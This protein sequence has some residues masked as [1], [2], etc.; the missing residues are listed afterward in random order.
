MQW[1]LPSWN[2]DFR[3]VPSPKQPAHTELLIAKP[4]AGEVSILNRFGAECEG[5]GWLKA[6]KKV[7]TGLWLKKKIT[8]EAPLEEV[9]PL[10]VGL[11]KPGPAVLTAV[12]YEDGKLTTCSGGPAE[13]TKLADEIAKKP[14]KEQPK[15]SATVSRPTPCCPD[16]IP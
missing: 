8:I 16:C 14:E 5:R 11:T 7:S 4:T 6:W 10:L 1:Y 9:G 12:R 15:A 2:G 3:L 13:L